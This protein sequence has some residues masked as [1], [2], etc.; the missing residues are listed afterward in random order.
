MTRALGQ[1]THHSFHPLTLFRNIS[2]W[3]LAGALLALAAC[4]AAITGDPDEN[5]PPETALSVRDESLVDNLDGAERLASTVAVEWSGTDADGFVAAYELR[6]YDERD[7]VGPEEG[8]ALTTALDTLIL[9]PIRL[10]ES[11]AN[12][13]FEVRAVDNEQARDPSPARTV[14]P[15]QNAPPSLRLRAFELPPEETFSIFSFA[16]EARDPEG[17]DNLDRIEVS[18]N[19]TTS[20]VA[21]PPD[22]EFATF[23]AEID[24]DDPTQTETRARVYVGRGFQRTDIYVPGLRLDAENTFYARAV[25]LTDTSSV[26]QQYTWRVNKPKGRVL[27]VNDHRNTFTQT[28]QGYHI[29]LLESYLPDD[30]GIDVWDLSMPFL[31]GSSGISVRSEALPSVADPDIRQTLALY[32]HI[33][34]IST[35]TTNEIAG[36][37]LPFVASAM[38]LFFENGGSLLV[39]SPIS[40]P[41][42]E[43]DNLGNP[44]ILLMPLTDLISFPDTLRTSL[45]LPTN[46]DIEP[47]EPVPGLGMRLPPLEATRLLIT[48]LPYVVGGTNIPLYRAQYQYITVDGRGRGD[49]FGPATVASISED[50]RVALI[51]LPFADERTG[52]DLF[53]AANPAEGGPRE[54]LFMILESLGFPKR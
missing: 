37:N 44:A 28:V 19:D 22:V 35:S 51:A 15:I 4:D 11:A 24:R 14:F 2:A 52:R 49:W 10:R 29:R 34:W 1:A 18:F 6:Y 3:A 46:A 20:F 25:D 27:F 47:V 32:D 30:V 16:W 50:R 8:W 17:R 54:A 23:V 41:V 39:H 7:T 36:N 33:Y 42:N 43:E 53:R 9:L 48:T 5:R 12:V 45:R 13:V 38:D 26:R 31:T 40:L 21:L